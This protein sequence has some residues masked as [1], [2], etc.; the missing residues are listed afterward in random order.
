MLNLGTPESLVVT[1]LPLAIVAWGIVDAAIRPDWAWQ[2]AGQN[3]VL[4]IL[5]QS[6][7]LLCCFVVGLVSAIVYLTAIRSQVRRQQ[8]QQYGPPG[9]PP[10]PG[11]PPPG[12]PPSW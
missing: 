5:L 11:P 3:K 7:G 4:W 12:S 9:T 8:D 6:L 2:R 1:V 10:Y